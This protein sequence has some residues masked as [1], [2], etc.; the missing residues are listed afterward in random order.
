M[1]KVS[2][3]LNLSRM[4][5][6]D[7]N[8][9]SQRVS[10]VWTRGQATLLNDTASFYA[11]AAPAQLIGVNDGTNDCILVTDGSALKKITTG[12]TATTYTQAG[13]ASTI[14]S[15]TT[16]GKQ[17]FFIN[18]SHVH[19]GSISGATSDTEIYNASSTTRATIRY[20]KQRL[21]AGYWQRHL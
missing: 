14:Y 1:D 7:S 21:I 3:S 13:T 18:G 6:F 10:D 19:R 11:G 8:T 4:S 9:Q 16:N 5:H 12:G 17:Y 15:L 2:S 20:V